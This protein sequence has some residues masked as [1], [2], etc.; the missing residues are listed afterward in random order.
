MDNEVIATKLTEHENRIK[1]AEHR[2]EELEEKTD[3]I[4]SLTLSVKELAMS[5][6]TMADGLRD[7]KN[8]T[9]DLDERL[10]EVEKYPIKR[11]AEIHDRYVSQVATLIIGALV[12][13]LLKTLFNL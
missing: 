8:D 7:T 9:A 2:I 1:V 12:G 13:F 10:S 6:K 5:V 4:E 11:K 3:R